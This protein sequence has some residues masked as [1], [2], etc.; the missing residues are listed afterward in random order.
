MMVDKVTESTEP[1]QESIIYEGRVTRAEIVHKLA[2]APLI[3]AQHVSVTGPA[4]REAILSVV[5]GVDQLF[6]KALENVQQVHSRWMWYGFDCSGQ[7]LRRGGGHGTIR[8]EAQKVQA[9]NLIKWP[10]AST[11][12]FD[13]ECER[14]HI[15][16][17]RQKKE[18]YAK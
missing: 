13:M 1:L 9:G 5:A 18:A 2:I 14:N 8:A 12:V 7:D 6:R 17:E 4:E 15:W 16:D 11:S 3:T 10:G